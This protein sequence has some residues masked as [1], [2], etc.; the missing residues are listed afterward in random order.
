MLKKWWL[1]K[2]SGGTS[3]SVVSQLEYCVPES[4]CFSRLLRV[5]AASDGFFFFSGL[6]V[7]LDVVIL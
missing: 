7:H 1:G 4:F 2:L 3:C 6:N 5:H